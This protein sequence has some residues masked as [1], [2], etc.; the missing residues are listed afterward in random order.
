MARWL[1]GFWH[2]ACMTMTSA[3]T[4]LA[5]VYVC[6]CACLQTTDHI[7]MGE[8]ENKLSR[9]LRQGSNYLKVHAWNGVC[10]PLILCGCSERRGGCRPL[11]PPTYLQT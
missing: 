8:S 5:H 9:T 7:T 4:N 3:A 10:A 2:A 6:V 11:L 1:P